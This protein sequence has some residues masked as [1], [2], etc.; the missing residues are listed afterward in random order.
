VTGIGDDAFA[1]DLPSAEERVMR[2][3]KAETAETRKRIVETA[4]RAFRRQGIAG[5]G[6][7]EIMATA[8]LTHGG[9]YRH[10]ASKDQLVTEALSATEKNLVRDSRAAAEQGAAAMLAVLEDYVTETYRDKVEDGCPLAAMGSELVRADAETRHAATTSFRKIVETMAPFM[11]SPADAEGIDTALSLL[12]NMVGAL[13]VAR[14]VDDRA[15]SDRILATAR[16]RI[17]AAVNL[18]T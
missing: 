3:S 5:T 7:A 8:G 6:V 2:K 9:F 1:A 10:F 16:Q 13:T 11:R 15:L 18:K 4:A 12:T 17:E 14:M